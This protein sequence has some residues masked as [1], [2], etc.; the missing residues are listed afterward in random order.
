MIN[1][2][3]VVGIKRRVMKIMMLWRLV[4]TKMIIM[5]VN[6]NRY[7][8]IIIRYHRIKIIT[9]ITTTT[10]TTHQVITIHSRSTTST[11]KKSSPST[12]HNMRNFLAYY[13]Q[14]E[15]ST[16]SNRARY[17]SHGVSYKAME[18]K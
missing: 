3:L 8:S 6:S 14:T 13:K 7:L 2:L 12:T 11:T 18:M 9:Y 15:K 4:I 5:V 16:S 10:I 1:I 17:K